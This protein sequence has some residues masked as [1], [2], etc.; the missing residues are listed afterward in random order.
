VTFLTSAKNGTGFESEDLVNFGKATHERVVVAFATVQFFAL[1][2][3]QKFA[4][5]A[6]SFP[7]AVS[8]LIMLAGVVWLVVTGDLRFVPPRT[9]A[10]LLF[11]GFCFLS[12]SLANGSWSSLTQL[13]LL[14]VPMALSADVSPT[15]YRRI[16]NRFIMLM[17]LPAGIM[18]VQYAYQK[19]TSL[20]DPINLEKFFPQSVLM[21]GFFYNA[22]FPW[23]STFSRPNGFFFLE[24]SFASAFTASAA[25]LEISYFRRPWCAVL[26]VVATVL[27]LGGT[28]Y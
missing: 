21:P 18:I 24:P 22:R 1:I 25:I 4:L 13:I 8:M 7:L 3:L 19:L 23:Y 16:M 9:A 15:L 6:P 10:L 26:L 12:E 2:Y 11:L 28:D 5:F 27:S 14:Y 20:S 17:I